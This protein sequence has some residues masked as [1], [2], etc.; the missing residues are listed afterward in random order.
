MTDRL[1]FFAPGKVVQQGSHNFYGNGR[2]GDA[3]KGLK[4]W[5]ADVVKAA[6]KA[7][8]EVEDRSLFP[9][10]GPLFTRIT[11]VIARPKTIKRPLPCVAPDL[12]KYLRGANDALTK[13]SVWADD[14]RVV[15]STEDK[16]Y[17]GW[18]AGMDEPGAHITVGTID[19]D[20]SMGRWWL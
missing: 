18:F 17:T 4:V 2:V 5:R 1:S 6:V 3:A 16:V 10:D 7:L 15:S 12:D 14:G 8:S 9:L 19:V 13:A 11:F 20:E